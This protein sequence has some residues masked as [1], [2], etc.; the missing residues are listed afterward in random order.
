MRLYERLTYHGRGYNGGRGGHGQDVVGDARGGCR[1]SSGRGRLYAKV[2]FI[3]CTIH[4]GVL[5]RHGVSCR[6]LPS[7]SDDRRVRSVTSS[8]MDVPSKVLGPFSH[9]SDVVFIV[10]NAQ[11]PVFSDSHPFRG[12]SFILSGVAEFSL[13][14]AVVLSTALTV[15]SVL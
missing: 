5:A 2:A 3:S 4:E 13:F 9:D 12:A 1:G 10:Y 8:A 11:D 7:L 6:V 15:S 14:V